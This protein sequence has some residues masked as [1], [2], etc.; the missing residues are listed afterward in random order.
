MEN[1]Q[2]FGQLETAMNIKKINI[3]QFLYVVE[4]KY[5]I[6]TFFFNVRLI[7]VLS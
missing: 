4:N 1:F 7:V 5:I 2:R 3:T 6:I